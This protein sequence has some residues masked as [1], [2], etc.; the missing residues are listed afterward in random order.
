[1]LNKILNL[2]MKHSRNSIVLEGGVGSQ[3]SGGSQAEFSDFTCTYSSIIFLHNLG[4][5]P[6]S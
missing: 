4:K 6:G 3:D 5:G 2:S 1:M